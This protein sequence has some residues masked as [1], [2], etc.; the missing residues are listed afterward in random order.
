LP[1]HF[2]NNGSVQM[3]DVLP[4]P[5][6]V[7][8]IP[9]HLQKLVTSKVL[10]LLIFCFV[11]SKFRGNSSNIAFILKT[12]FQGSFFVQ[13]KFRSSMLG[14]IIVSS[15]T[16][17]LALKELVIMLIKVLKQRENKN[18]RIELST[19]RCQLSRELF[20]LYL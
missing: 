4:G 6:S 8:E 18:Q 10:E 11:C 9:K 7:I 14:P 1:S 2:S 5:L 17:I 19:L 16:E 3:T 12:I 20:I 15:K 13:I